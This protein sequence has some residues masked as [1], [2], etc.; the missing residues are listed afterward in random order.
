M[1][2][3]QRYNELTY[4]V[5]TSIKWNITNN[6][7]LNYVVCLSDTGS[8]CHGV[9]DR[10]CRQKSWLKCACF[11]YKIHVTLEI[12]VFQCQLLFYITV[13]KW[14]KSSLMF[15]IVVTSI[16]WNI[17]NNNS[18]KLLESIACICASWQW[19]STINMTIIN[20]FFIQ[21]CFKDQSLEGIIVCNISLYTS[22]Y[23]VC[24]FIV[25]LTKIH[26]MI[27]TY[28]YIYI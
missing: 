10:I 4:I 21:T 7:K 14:H 23:N 28:I 15:Y 25:S 13:I 27:N 9:T 2:F 17:T 6:N 22:H 16:K 8:T 5:V 20:D 1:Y 18:L 19:I 24:Q 12:N 26:K 3:W 11:L